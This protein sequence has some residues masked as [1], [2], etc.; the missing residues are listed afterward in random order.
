MGRM[1][2]YEASKPVLEMGEQVW[3]K[4]M[5]TH[6]WH[7][8]GPLESR[9]VAATWSG[10]S[11]KTGEHLVILEGGRHL[12]RVRTVKRRPAEER[13]SADAIR[14]VEV[15]LRRPEAEK[16]S[17]MKVRRAT[18]DDVPTRDD[19]NKSGVML[20]EPKVGEESCKAP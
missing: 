18:P 10:I 12:L 6:A 7:K 19:L 1:R 16:N 4:P 8:R 9:W 2:G 17:G 3:A 15:S 11:P 5:R 13:W 14:E 20:E